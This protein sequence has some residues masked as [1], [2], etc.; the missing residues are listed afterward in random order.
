M[1]EQTNYVLDIFDKTDS[2][3]RLALGLVWITQ[4][5]KLTGSSTGISFKQTSSDILCS[6]TSRQKSSIVFGSGY[7]VVINRLGVRNPFTRTALI[8]PDLCPVE[9]LGFKNTLTDTS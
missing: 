6:I 3:S 9:V 8:Y 2:D 4:Y 1:T 7:C 5:I